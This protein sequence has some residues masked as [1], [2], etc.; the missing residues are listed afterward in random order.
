MDNGTTS[1]CRRSAILILVRP[2][3][4]RTRLTPGIVQSAVGKL[5]RPI[6]R[7]KILHRL[8]QIGQ[9]HDW[10]ILVRRCVPM[11]GPCVKSFWRRIA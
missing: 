7:G 2:T 1:Q 3:Y 10:A 5:H 9:A 8:M 4:D 6:R 11:S